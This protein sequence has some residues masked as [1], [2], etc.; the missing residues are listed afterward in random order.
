MVSLIK[1]IGLM[2]QVNDLEREVSYDETKSVF[3]ECGTNKSPGPDGFTFE[4]FC[5]FWSI[6]DKDVV[7]AVKAFLSLESNGVDGIVWKMAWFGWNKMYDR[8]VWSL[9]SSGEFSV[10][11]VRKYID[12]ILLPKEPVQTR[13]VKVVP[14]K[15]NILAWIVW[16]DNLPTRFNLSSKGLEIPSLLCSLCNVSV[17]S[18]SC[19][20]F[21][22]SLA[23]QLWN[24]VFRWLLD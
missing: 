22:C 15:V 9:V 12:D 23:R 21:S 11:S 4:L 6:I 3:W 18:T 20:F 14:I 17:E 13:W 7:A 5:K 19:L 8:W 2:I 10:K 16:L 24:K 1:M